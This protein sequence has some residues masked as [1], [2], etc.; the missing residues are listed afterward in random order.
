[1]YRVFTRKV[2]DDTGLGTKPV[3][4]LN[5]LKNFDVY[6]YNEKGHMYKSDVEGNLYYS[7]HIQ[8]PD[9]VSKYI[10]FMENYTGKSVK[11]ILNCRAA[12]EDDKIRYIDCLLTLDYSTYFTFT[13]FNDI[14]ALIRID[15]DNDGE[16]VFTI[17]GI[18]SYSYQCT[19]ELIKF[20]LYHIQFNKEKRSQVWEDI[21]YKIKIEYEGY[22]GINDEQIYKILKY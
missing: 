13:E 21:V 5:D 4:V 17:S 18:A 19:E 2:D 12:T 9:F 7:G 3:E 20:I 11:G 16:Y 10:K 1:M 8:I 6:K 15:N 22:E 14:G